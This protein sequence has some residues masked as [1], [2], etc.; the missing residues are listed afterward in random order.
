[1]NSFIP[2]LH[3]AIL[4]SRHSTVSLIL[5]VVLTMLNCILQLDVLKALEKLTRKHSERLKA[6]RDLLTTRGSQ[7]LNNYELL[8]AL[9]D[10]VGR[11]N[12]SSAQSSHQ[13]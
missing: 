11:G 12:H 5:P 9:F 2:C 1:M 6:V 4:L 3:K 7:T 8:L 13:P 10:Q